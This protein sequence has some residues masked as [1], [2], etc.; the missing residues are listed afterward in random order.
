MLKPNETVVDGHSAT[1]CRHDGSEKKVLALVER[2][3]RPFVS[4]SHIH[5]NAIRATL[6]TNFDRATTPLTERAAIGPNFAAMR[7]H[8]LI[9]T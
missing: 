9:Q 7:A 8:G 5:G 3:G 2:G 6:V 1:D 4:C